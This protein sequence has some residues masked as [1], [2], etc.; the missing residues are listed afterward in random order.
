[1]NIDNNE[2]AVLFEAIQTYGED[3]QLKIL[4]EEMSELQ[5]EICKYWRGDENGLRIAEE[6]AD[7][8]IMLE[9]LKMMFSM[10]FTVRQFGKQKLERLEKRL[11]ENH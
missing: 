9:Q 5:K 11:H 10:E 7:V 3:S 8:E 1:M 4:L 6:T 2:R